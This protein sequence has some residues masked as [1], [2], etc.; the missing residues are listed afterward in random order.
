MTWVKLEHDFA[1][2]PK[3]MQAGPLSMLLHVKAI[4]YCARFLTDGFVPMAVVRSLI[5]WSGCDGMEACDNRILAANLVAVGS[6]DEVPGGFMIHDYLEYQFSKERVLA[7]R[8]A[9]S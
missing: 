6:W 7:D 9:K 4:C 3:M 8:R 2:H 1:D 5:D